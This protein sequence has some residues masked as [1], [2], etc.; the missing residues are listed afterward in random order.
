MATP[1]NLIVGSVEIVIRFISDDLQVL[2][3][4]RVAL[5]NS[6]QGKVL[7]LRTTEQLEDLT[8]TTEQ[9]HLSAQDLCRRHPWPALVMGPDVVRG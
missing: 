9:L 4:R 2:K 6:D 1:P 8:K 7:L 5:K 3:E